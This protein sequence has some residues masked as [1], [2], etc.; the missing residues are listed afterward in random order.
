MVELN[1]CPVKKV[2]KIGSKICLPS[3]IRFSIFPSA[4]KVRQY[5]SKLT[6]FITL[7]SNFRTTFFVYWS[8]CRCWCRSRCN[9]F[10][11]RGL[12]VLQKNDIRIMQKEG[13]WY[14]LWRIF[15]GLSQAIIDVIN[16]C[17][18]FLI[19]SAKCNLLNGVKY[20]PFKSS[21]M[22]P[23][24][25]QDCDIIFLDSKLTWKGLAL[26]NRYLFY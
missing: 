11:K 9:T 6:W 10:A 22:S 14:F 1:H 16:R 25:I 21:V 23:E 18:I 15:D 20:F 13:L 2:I 7:V 26:E 19:G 17:P 12:S 3:K 4:R 5:F 24:I 8:R